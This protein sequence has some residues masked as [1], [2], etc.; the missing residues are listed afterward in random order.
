MFI[1]R[2]A[3]GAGSSKG[4][5]A[6]NDIWFTQ[7]SSFKKNGKIRNVKVALV[8][9]RVN[10][11]GGAERILGVLHEIWPEASLYTSVYNPQ[12]APWAKIFPKVIPSFLKSFPFAMHHELYAPLMPL[13]FESFTLDD[14]E[15]VISVTSEAAK[16]I[17]TKPKTLHICYCLTPT[18][19]LWSHHDDYF[20]N[21]LFRWLTSPIV[22]YLREWDKTASQRP[23]YYLAISENVALRIKK[24]YQ[25]EAE[26]I[27]PPV[28]TEKFNLKSQSS[29]LKD[30]N[31][32]SKVKEKME[33]F[34]VVSR[35]VPYKRID[36]AIE[37]LNQ[38]GWP[39][40]IVGTGSE[41]GRLKGMA[42]SNIEFLGE[43][44]DR[45]LLRYYQ[46]CQALIFPQEEDFG[47]VSI[48]TQA[49]GKPVIA[50]GGGGALETVIQGKTGE[51]FYPQESQALIKR[52]KDFKDYDY[53]REECRE[54]AEKFNK[55]NF[56]K[57][58]KNKVENL[59][60]NYLKT[61]I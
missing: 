20:K 39:L 37:A 35:L 23:D 38:L 49:C 5:Y 54:N 53:S 1:T 4:I 42:R 19:Y 40:K 2:G 33:Y 52:L 61:I 47:L 17:I 29:K 45:E 16:G 43:L 36:I 55:E 56:K 30:T 31:Q 6:E 57:K 27:Y 22:S 44:T 8:Y 46:G 34:L 18:R 28:D 50:F 58:F 13:A 21:G 51:F 41:M 32:N 12:T 24:Y 48:E 60:Q 9:D 10:K 26:I 3:R 14:Y 11:I 25:R 15:V 59:W 7:Q